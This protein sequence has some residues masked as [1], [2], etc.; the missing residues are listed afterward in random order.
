MTDLALDRPVQSQ[1]TDNPSRIDEFAQD[2]PIEHAPPPAYSDIYGQ[3]GFNQDGFD[4]QAK[5]ASE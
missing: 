3:V 2:T 1:H 4:T 5:V